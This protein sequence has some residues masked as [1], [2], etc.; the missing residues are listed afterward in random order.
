MSVGMEGEMRRNS[1]CYW[2]NGHAVGV[3]ELLQIKQLQQIE[4]VLMV[5]GMDESQN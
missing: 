2:R 3:A 5:V 4:L 1:I